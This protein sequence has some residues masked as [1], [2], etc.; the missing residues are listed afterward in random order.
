MESSCVGHGVQVLTRD[1]PFEST[2][3]GASHWTIIYYASAKIKSAKVLF[4]KYGDT[5]LVL[6]DE[7]W[8]SLRMRRCNASARKQAWKVEGA[9]YFSLLSSEMT[10]QIWQ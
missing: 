10:P 4:W 3:L 1:V 6:E 5:V 7:K 8:E 2:G 9:G